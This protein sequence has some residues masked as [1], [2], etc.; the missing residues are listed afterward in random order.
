MPYRF[1]A[2]GV[3]ISLASGWT[4]YTCYY[5]SANT[6]PLRTALVLL[7]YTTFLWGTLQRASFQLPVRSWEFWLMLTTIFDAGLAQLVVAALC[8]DAWRPIVDIWV[9]ITLTLGNGVIWGWFANCNWGYQAYL[10]IPASE[11]RTW[12]WVLISLTTLSCVLASL[13]NLYWLVL[14]GLGLVGIRWRLYVSNREMR[15][16]D[17]L[18]LFASTCLGPYS[19]GYAYDHYQWSIGIHAKLTVLLLAM[20]SGLYWVQYCGT[21]GYIYTAPTRSQRRRREY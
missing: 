18:W 11:H 16:R 17:W 8:P 1:L 7:L 13:H 9:V 3:A 2:I 10:G 6:T 21:L 15:Y 14:V 4:A 5:Y 20:C 12:V 19:V